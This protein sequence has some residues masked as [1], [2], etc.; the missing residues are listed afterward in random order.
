MSSETL[1]I[2][3]DNSLAAQA[4][5]QAIEKFT[6]RK[7]DVVPCL[8]E[9]MDAD[10]DCGF[11]QAVYGLMLH[12]A[13]QSSLAPA[14]NEVL[15][16][17]SRV[18]KRMTVREQH[19]VSALAHG[20]AG[21]LFAMVDSY[22]CI[23]RDN[24]TDIL[25]LTL[26][27]GELFWLGEMKR[28]Q[29]VSASVAAE[30]NATIPGYADFLA[31]RAF[32]LE[33]CGMY[34]QAETAGREAVELRASNVWGAHAVAHVL[35]M[36]GRSEEGV[37]WLG[38]LQ[39]NW[40]ETNQMKFHIW[41]HQCLFHLERQEHDAVLESYDLWIRN[42]DQPL[43]QAMPDLYIDL[44]NGS[45]ML[46]R[47]EL[48]GVSVGER[49]QEMAELVTPRTDDMSS[50]FTSAHYAMIL[51]AVGDYDGCERLI[52]QMNAFAVSGTHTLASRYQ[53]AAIPAAE[54]AVAHRRGDFQQVLDKL[55]PARQSLW[56]MGASHAQR[57]VFFQ[58]LVDA[59]AKLKRH[60]LLKSLLQEIE[61]LGFA[62][63]SQRV[64]YAHAAGQLRH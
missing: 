63:P 22:E 3:T 24:P 35:L 50:A 52:E 32:D 58:I 19:Y 56:Q 26:C 39:H 11:A 29:Q 47:L 7:I 54:A 23:L 49:W 48:A 46:W 38:G 27:Q 61:I 45:S 55:L 10:P 51:A 5:E 15:A 42:R 53:L 14:I 12:G 30:W 9:A 18:Q 43:V 37:N 17:A 41:W 21:D 4:C 36:Q 60:D 44:Q 28:S 8:Q 33:E 20:A 64:G 13:R 1:T 2:T 16:N 31:C 34:D 25:A 40:L 62:E 57:D 6:Q 59:A